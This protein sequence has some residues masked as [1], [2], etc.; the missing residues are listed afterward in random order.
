MEAKKLTPVLYVEEIESC[1]Q[2]WTELGFEKTVELPEG[3]KLGFVIL[4]KDA[5]EVMYQTRVSVAHDLPALADAPQR[6]SFLFI[7]VDDADAVEKLMPASAYIIPR[8]QT[9]Y[10]SDEIIVREPGGNVVTFAQMSAG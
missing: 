4:K 9:F 7:E 3:D 1:L 10:G 6:G 2:F 8:R 5:V